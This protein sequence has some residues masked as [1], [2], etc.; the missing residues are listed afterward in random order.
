LLL[1]DEKRIVDMLKELKL[2][3][4]VNFRNNYLKPALE[5]GYIEMTDPLKPNNPNQ[6]YRLTQKGKELKSRL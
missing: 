5:N 3:D 4:K 6:K 1:T 2:T